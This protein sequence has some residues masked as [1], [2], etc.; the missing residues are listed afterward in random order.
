MASLRNDSPLMSHGA[1][2]PTPDARADSEADVAASSMDD[3]LR[4]RWLT[5]LGAGPG[6]P[7][8]LTRR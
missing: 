1:M 2:T 5:D 7:G 8:P 6:G 3:T 4:A